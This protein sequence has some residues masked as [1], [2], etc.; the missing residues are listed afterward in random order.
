MDIIRKINNITFK[1]SLV[2]CLCLFN[3]Y[4][5]QKNINLGN[6]TKDLVKLYTV[7][8]I[9]NKSYIGIIIFKDSISRGLS[10]ETLDENFSLYK[11]TSNYK[12]FTYKKHK[13]I[14]FC[15][16]TSSNECN[17][18]FKSINLCPYSSTKNILDKEPFSYEINEGTKKWLLRVDQN[19]KITDISGKMIEAEIANP[20]GFKEFLKKYSVLKLYQLNKEG[21][22]VFP[23]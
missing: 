8:S 20:E 13:I 6:L 4:Y 15:G 11:K 7:D 5:S 12:W 23:H 14:I 22:I 10:I 17:N 3:K 18:L 9:K 19:L 21:P 2:F 16:F 1:I